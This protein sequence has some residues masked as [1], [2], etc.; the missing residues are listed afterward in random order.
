VQI[1]PSPSMFTSP[2]PPPTHRLCTSVR[3][4]TRAARGFERRI[5]K[6]STSDGHRRRTLTLCYYRNADLSIIIHPAAV[7]WC[8]GIGLVICARR[9]FAFRLT[10]T[11][12]KFS[13]GCDEEKKFTPPLPP[14]QRTDPV[15]RVARLNATRVQKPHA[16]YYSNTILLSSSLYRRFDVQM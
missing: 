15:F 11:R 2:S 6:M 5:R 16:L 8:E 10:T 3:A 9:P 4:R 1:Q 13:T 14:P 12:D 7:I